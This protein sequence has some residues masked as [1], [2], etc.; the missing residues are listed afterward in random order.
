M[1]GIELEAARRQWIEN[2]DEEDGSSA[3]SFRVTYIRHMNSER[4][5]LKYELVNENAI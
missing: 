1:F 3:E 4:A 5:S 2:Y